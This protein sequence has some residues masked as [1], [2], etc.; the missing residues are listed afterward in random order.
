MQIEIRNPNTQ[1]VGEVFAKGSNVMQGYFNNPSA[2]ADSIGEDGWLNT[3]DMGKVNHRGQLQIVGRAKEVVVT[4]SGENIY[5]DDV[6]NLL[7][8]I[9]GLLEYTLVGIS[10]GKGGERLGLLG[11]LDTE[12]STTERSTHH[13]ETLGRVKA[14]IQHLSPA[15]RPTVIRLV[16]A[17]L[18]RTRTRKVQRRACAE[19]MERIIAATENTVTGNI[20]NNISTILQRVSGSTAVIG[21][22]TNLKDELGF[23]SLM[24]VELSSALSNMRGIQ[25]PD[26][27]AINRCD[28]V[29]DLLLLLNQ[30]A[31]PES[32][33]Q[34]TQRRIPRPFVSPLR[35][36]L[37]A[38]QRA[39]Y[40][41]VLKTEVIGRANIPMNRQCIVISNHCSHLDMGLVKTALGS[42]GE[43]LTALAAKDYFFEGNE[44]Q[45]AYFEQLTN[46]E[47]IDRKRLCGQFKTSP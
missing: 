20:S 32:T 29:N 34:P 17:E 37:G 42:Y 15:Q 43:R 16:E 35:R 33:A 28:T 47:P 21:P 22:Q 36:V 7:G 2:T 24:S 39:L 41:R 9:S 30:P 3:G 1:G 10:D 27:D 40:E 4:A 14:R 18:P 45:V 19:I 5:L 8:P 11:V 38:A 46:L 31:E 25:A 12:Q 13:T 6:E 44:W 26:P 23:D